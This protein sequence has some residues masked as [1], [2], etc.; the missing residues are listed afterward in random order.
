MQDLK[1]ILY[2]VNIL[3]VSGSTAQ[4]VELLTFDSRTAKEN[5]VFFAIEGSL[6]DGHEYI[7]N[8]IDAGCKI[9]VVSKEIKPKKDITLIEVKDTHKALAIMASNFY[10]EP[11]K[12]LKLIG[13]T[14]TNGK[15]TIAT[16]LYQLF[17]KLEFQT[18]LISTVVN[19]I[20]DQD[21]PSTHTTPDPISLNAL[22]RDMV[23]EGCSHCFMEVSSHAIHQNRIGGLFFTGGVFTNITH[24]HL[25]YHKTFKEYI[26]VKKAFFDILPSSAFALTNTDDKNGMVMLQNTA[27]KKKTYGLKSMT[28]YKA[29]VLEN[30]FSGLVLSIQN[31]ELWTKLIGDF[32]AYNLL[33][34]YAVTQEL[35]VDQTEALTVISQLESVEGRFDYIRSD[36][37]VTAIVDYAHTPDALEN[38]L[39]TIENI[40]TRNET[41]YT[42]VGCGGDRDKTKR[43]EMA[44][45]ACN[46][47]DKVILTSDNPRSEDPNTI[48]DDMMAGVDGVHFKKTLSI[49]DR[50]Q[51]IKTAVSMSEQND[52]ILIAGKGHEKYQDIKGVKHDFDDMQTIKELFKKLNK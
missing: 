13:I 2:G 28:D 27:A 11:S 24:D 47:S 37:G 34:V 42:V 17:S 50:E 9:L 22:L 39:K 25:D 32:N 30:Q 48:I 46:L 20:C 8:A 26:N 29:K 14:G 35:G 16:L 4:S 12:E 41:V 19:K 43:P 10:G 3:A 45:I 51:A 7:Q 44:A 36:G 5:S 40:R 18:G 6:S 31:T 15:T 38:V 33:A 21:I 23:E 52:I 1:D 49:V